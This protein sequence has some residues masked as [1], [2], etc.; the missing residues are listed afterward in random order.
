MYIIFSSNTEWFKEKGSILTG[1]WFAGRKII[2]L[3]ALLFLDQHNVFLTLYIF[4]TAWL[5]SLLH[6]QTI[7]DI[8]QIQ[9][10]YQL[11]P[12]AIQK[13]GK[14][15]Y[16]NSNK[17]KFGAYFTVYHKPTN[18]R[19]YMSVIKKTF[20]RGGINYVLRL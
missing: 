12:K 6:I 15:L 5:I 1:G 4:F 9:T 20:N 10:K 19:L 8:F 14:V 13:L 16:L 17:V 11:K 7:H 3:I 2:I 18:S